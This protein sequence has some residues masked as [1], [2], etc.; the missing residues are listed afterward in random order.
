MEHEHRL[1]F[2]DEP[3]HV[4]G[5]VLMLHGGAEHSLRAVDERNKQLWRA[6]WMFEQ[7]SGRF[8]R[9]G[10]RTALL[11]FS[12]VGWNARHGEPAPVSDTRW[13][14][15]RLREQY[16]GLPVVLLGHSMGA[17]TAARSADD[18]AVAGV[19]GLAPWFPAGDPV[20]QLAGKHLVG[21]NGRSDRITSARAPR[22]YLERA[23]SV[24]ASTRF[25][26]RGRIGHYML[27]DIRG[28]NRVAVEESLAIVDRVT[29]LTAGS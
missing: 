24:A 8:A 11:R 14:L 17:R 2:S 29:G 19:V 18:P 23:A 1:T 4:R 20:E 12:L 10:V 26:D 27:R 7:V 16:A 6:R 22:R 9:S 3:A 25:V 28:W 15:D 21:A 13:A 5:L